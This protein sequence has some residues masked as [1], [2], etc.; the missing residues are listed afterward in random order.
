LAVATLDPCFEMS[1][2]SCECSE[3][4]LNNKENGKYKEGKLYRARYSSSKYISEVGHIS[5]V[6]HISDNDV[7]EV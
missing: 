1:Y 7:Q 4:D 2:N 5:E 3:I 6:D